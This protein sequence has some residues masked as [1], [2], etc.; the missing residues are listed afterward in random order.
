M[1]ISH[2]ADE[3]NELVETAA[4]RDLVS[5]QSGKAHLGDQLIHEDDYAYGTDEAAQEWPAKDVVEK[6]KTKQASNENECASHTCYHASY[7]S[8]QG[9]VLIFGCPPFDILPDD[10]SS[11]QRSWGFRPN[12][13]LRTG[14]EDSVYER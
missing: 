12:D 6:A 14:T 7:L 8:I 3:K 10:L 5:S 2:I 13:H 4:M 11:K 1:R 9:P